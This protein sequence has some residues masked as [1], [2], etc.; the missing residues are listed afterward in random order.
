MNQE[1]EERGVGNNQHS[2][3]DDSRDSVARLIASQV[4][5]TMSSLLS[6]SHSG[7][8]VS[9]GF[10]DQVPSTGN[11]NLQRLHFLPIVIL[12]P[13]SIQYPYLTLQCPPLD[14]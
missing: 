1:G 4:S 7:F 13:F 8:S 10:V 5:R 3:P 11:K 14:L 9:S 2:S 12:Y 6:V